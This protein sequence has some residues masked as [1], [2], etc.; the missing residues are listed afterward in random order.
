[1]RKDTERCLEKYSINI[2]ANK[3]TI[4]AAEAMIGQNEV[5]HFVSPSNI[6]VTPRNTV[7]GKSYTGAI[8]ITNTKIYVYHKAG[9]ES[10]T[11]SFS[12]SDLVRVSYTANGISAAEFT[13]TMQDASINFITS[14]NKKNAGLLYDDLNTLIRPVGSNGSVPAFTGDPITEI[15]RYKEL[16]DIG[17]ITADEYNA[18]KKQLLGI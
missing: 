10:G 2:F 3:K 14:A 4:E 6:K 9:W 16:L 5:I 11:E 12:I 1:M 18:K 17:A 7:R 13:L 15:K 8:I